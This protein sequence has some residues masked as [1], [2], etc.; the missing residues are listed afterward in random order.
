MA[1]ALARP[2][3]LD[4]SSVV[5]LDAD[6]PHKG[7]RQGDGPVPKQRRELDN[8]C[9]TPDWIVGMA[10]QRAVQCRFSRQPVERAVEAPAHRRH[11]FKPNGAVGLVAHV[12]ALGHSD[13]QPTPRQLRQSPFASHHSPPPKQ[14]LARH[15]LHNL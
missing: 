6:R 7:R 10:F 15:G 2:D 1:Q 9:F 3:D 12:E 4:R 8:V 5:V 14:V 13:R 11:G